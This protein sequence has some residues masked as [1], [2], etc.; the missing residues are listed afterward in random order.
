MDAKT[1]YR[2]KLLEWLGDPENEIPQHRITW[3]RY[4]GISHQYFYTLFGPAE[5][6]ELEDEIL[7]L[8]RKRIAAS[9]MKV[10]AALLKECLRPGGDAAHKKLFY[11]RL[12]GWTEKSKVDHDFTS[13]D[14][15]V[16]EIEKAE[17]M[18]VPPETPSETQIEAERRVHNV[19]DDES[20]LH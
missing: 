2:Q 18:E 6:I 3:C 12:E 9:A 19:P 11:Q 20:K 4:L 1:G 10:D 15:I 8:R 17:A 16:K 13:L 5:L 7:M 14:D